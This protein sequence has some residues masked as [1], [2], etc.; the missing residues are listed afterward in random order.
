MAIAVRYPPKVKLPGISIQVLDEVNTKRHP[1]G[2]FMLI[3]IIVVN[4][5]PRVVVSLNGNSGSLLR[6][7]KITSLATTP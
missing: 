2:A 7:A 5:L 3:D 1:V 4:A 6:M